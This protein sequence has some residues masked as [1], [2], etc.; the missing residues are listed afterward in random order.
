MRWAV[1]AT[2]RAAKA[3]RR[4]PRLHLRGGVDRPHPIEPET[5]EQGDGEHGRRGDGAG[6]HRAAEPGLPGGDGSEP[7]PAEEDDG[8]EGRGLDR[9]RGGTD[10]DPENPGP[11]AG[12]QQPHQDHGHHH[13]VV[14]RAA[15]KDEDRQGARRAERHHL[16][17]VAAEVP[18]QPRR[19]RRSPRPARP[20]ATSRRSTSV[21]RIWWLAM[22]ARKPS[23]RRMSGPY[24]EGVLAQVGPAI[25]LNGVPPQHARPIDVGVD[26]A[27]HQLGLTGVAVDVEAKQRGTDHDGDR[28]D[29]DGLD[30]V[31]YGTPWVRGPGAGGT[32]A[33][34]R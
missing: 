15:E 33:T 26:V 16:G 34:R 17:P 25:V 19:A 9:R 31:A 6:E 7:A 1:P 22:V 29:G 23:R 18:G 10:G 27:A 20:T 3:D 2:T 8:E 30:H 32:A 11:A 28:P 5:G 24:G 4:D 21:S 14:V 13:Q 12:H